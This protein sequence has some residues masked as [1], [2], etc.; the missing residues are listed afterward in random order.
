MFNGNEFGGSSGPRTAQGLDGDCHLTAPAVSDI[1]FEDRLITKKQISEYFG[2]TERTVEV[3]M[4]RRY[5]P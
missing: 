4:R 1:P 5:I 2:I 3:W